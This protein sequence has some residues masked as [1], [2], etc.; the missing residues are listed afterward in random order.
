[1]TVAANRP[2]RILVATD[3]SAPAGAAV[4]RAGQ[5][6]RAHGAALTAL[7]VTGGGSLTG[8]LWV[9]ALWVVFQAGAA[10]PDHHHVIA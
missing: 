5:L 7:H 2:R 3:F 9:L 6:A 10:A 4:A 1:M 8:A